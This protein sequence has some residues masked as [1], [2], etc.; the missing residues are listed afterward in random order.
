MPTV[1]RIGP[2]RFF[3]YAGDKFEPPHVHVERDNSKAKFWLDPVSLQSNASFSRGDINQIYR[4][5][6]E[7]Q[8]EL[9]R[10]WNEFFND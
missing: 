3:F 1:L 8:E 5:I 6:E 9:L 2:F 10:S 7:H 4:L